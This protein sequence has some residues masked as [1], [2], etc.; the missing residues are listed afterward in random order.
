[1]AF[2][3]SKNK[4]F[5][6]P[7]DGFSERGAQAEVTKEKPCRGNEVSPGFRVPD[8]SSGSTRPHAWRLLLRSDKAAALRAT[9]SRSGRGTEKRK[10]EK[11]C[12]DPL[13]F[14]F[15][16]A[17]EAELPGSVQFVNEYKFDPFL[18]SKREFDIITKKCIIE[19][20]SG[21]VSRRLKQLK[22]Q[23]NY[24][25]SKNKHHVLYAPDI[26]LATKKDYEKHGITIKTTIKDLIQQIKENGR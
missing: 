3:P 20:K 25:K 2:A 21:E 18:G 26:R 12:R 5:R 16:C 8:G 6:T 15:F 11:L 4:S 1:M 19:V 13:V 24:A 17:I 7:R 22:G 9:A 14:E 10:K 23:M